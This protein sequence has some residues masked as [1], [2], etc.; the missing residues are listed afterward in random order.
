[1]KQFI[2][3]DW[4]TSSFRLRLVEVSTKKILAEIKTAQGIAATYAL[5]KENGS[6]NRLTFYSNILFKQI[7]LL[8]QQYGYGLN[9]ISVVLSGMASSSIGMIEMPYKE[10]P[11]KT[12]GTDLVVQ[13]IKPVESKHSIIIISGAR[14]LHDAMRG[15]ETMLAGCNIA[16][17]PEAQ[18]F[19]FPGTHS[20]HIIIHSGMV[21]HLKTYMTGEFFEILST[22]SILSGSVE[23]GGTT[24]EYGAAFTM[25][26][27]ES[28]SSNLLNNVFHVRT[29]ELFDQLSKKDNYHY[30]SG[31][32]IGSELKDLSKDNYASI[33]LVA[34]GTLSELYVQALHALGYKENLFIKNADETLINGQ[35]L[36]A[37][38]Y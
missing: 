4:G 6:T 12:G 24:G 20:K 19:I 33:T 3:C 21:Q 5:W 23:N 16:N 25:G 34:S 10:I 22:K 2:S 37:N 1:M 36:I 26:V 27:K 30:L 31:L 18:L 32:L 14:S 9:D 17:T 35:S 28:V 29:N 13:H 11:F 15:E 7:A 8:E 38:Y